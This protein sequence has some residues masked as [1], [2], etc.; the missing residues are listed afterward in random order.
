VTGSSISPRWL[1]AVLVVAAAL[2]IPVGAASA[3]TSGGAQYGGDLGQSAHGGTGAKGGST[4]PFT[5]LDLGGVAATGIVL[6]GAGVALRAGVRPV[7]TR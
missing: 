5:G 2:L 3:Q 4:L 7:R 1:V 6:I